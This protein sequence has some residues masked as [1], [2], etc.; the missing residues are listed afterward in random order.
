MEE[1]LWWMSSGRW[2]TCTE[3]E[4]V[5]IQEFLTQLRSASFVN[6][7]AAFV[8][9]GDVMLEHRLE[10]LKKTSIFCRSAALAS[11]GR[12]R[13]PWRPCVAARHQIKSSVSVIH[14]FVFGTHTE[15]F[16]DSDKHHFT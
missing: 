7:A 15:L 16:C 14:S 3:I 9:S 1:A 12:L 4:V 11:V 5:H 8:L 13:F 2:V 10:L 6:N